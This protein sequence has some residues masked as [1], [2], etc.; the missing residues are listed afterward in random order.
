MAGRPVSQPRTTV[1][2]QVGVK[3]FVAGPLR[4]ILSSLIC[5]GRKRR[6]ALCGLAPSRPH[7]ATFIPPRDRRRGGSMHI[8]DYGIGMLGADGIVAGGTAMSAI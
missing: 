6:C 3:D 1:F 4:T 2:N 5:G 7:P 8:V